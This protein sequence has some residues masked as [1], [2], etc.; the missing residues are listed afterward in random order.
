MSNNQINELR[1]KIKQSEDFI[2]SKCSTAPTVGLILGSGLGELADEVEDKV[3][4]PYQE[5]PN[6]PISTAPGHAGR[7]V[8][9]KLGGK[10]VVVMQGRFHTYEGYTQQ[11]ITFPVR[12]MKAIGI[13]TLI[14]T[15]ATGGVNRNFQAGDLMVINDHINFTGSNPLIGPNDPELGPRFPV[16][17]NAYKKDLR[18]LAHKVAMEEG[19]RLQEG[20]YF[21]ITGPVYF[22]QSELRMAIKVGADSLGMSTVPEVIV[23]V[24]SGLKVLGIG[25]ITDMALP[26]SPHHAD[27]AEV[28]RV[29]SETGPKFRKL[30][31]AIL[32][33]M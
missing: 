22:T 26:D 14:V 9:G 8:I 21:G 7:L 20:V 27:E 33:A 4:I 18:E 1:T 25:N 3:V 16:M 32:K 29:A 2:K 19:I 24:H 30:L 5:I 6:F 10:T 12:V 28:L 23:A 17:F 11:E 13:D 15:C 31:K